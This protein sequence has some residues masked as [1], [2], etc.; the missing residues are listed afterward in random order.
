[1]CGTR[2]VVE[3]FRAR[4]FRNANERQDL[5]EIKK[6]KIH[7]NVESKQQRLRHFRVW[8]WSSNAVNT[9]AVFETQSIV[10]RIKK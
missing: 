3:Q 10:R 2:L 1:M 6:I 8:I 7:E 4:K 5:V 9:Y